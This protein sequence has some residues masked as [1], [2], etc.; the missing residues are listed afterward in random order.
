MDQ[1]YRDLRDRFLAGNDIS[2][3]EVQELEALRHHLSLKDRIRLLGYYETKCFDSPEKE[4]RQELILWL[5]ENCAT[6]SFLSSSHGVP[7]SDDIIFF[8]KVK[9]SW[10][11]QI[12]LHA[13]N[14]QVM[15]NAASQIA[16]CDPRTAKSILFDGLKKFPDSEALKKILSRIELVESTSRSE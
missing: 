16:F 10:L 12:E 4:K 5:I 1:E 13:N 9:E 7:S 3:E 6:N 2:S 15:A 11:K 8:E 14:P